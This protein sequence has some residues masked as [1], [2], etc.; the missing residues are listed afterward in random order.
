M[1]QPLAGLRVLELGAF[2]SAPYCGKLFAGY[3]AEVIKVEPPG[4]D[5]SRAHGPFKDGVPDPET[6][7]LFLYLNTGKRSVALDLRT[8]EGLDAFMR[9]AANADV[10]VENFRPADFRALGVTYQALWSV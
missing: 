8:S 10:V 4:G 9:L 2:V 3:G 7:A 5:P 6:S 1:S